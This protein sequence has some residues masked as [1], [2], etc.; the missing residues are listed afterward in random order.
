MDDVAVP[1]PARLDE[2]HR[3]EDEARR[4]RPARQPRARWERRGGGGRHPVHLRRGASAAGHPFTSSQIATPVPNSR[5]TAR[6]APALRRRASATP[7]WPPSRLLAAMIPAA[8]QA[9]GPKAANQATAAAPTISDNRP[10]S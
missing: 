9:T 5:T 3:D 6:N 1:A 4:L 7:A 2:P 8:A 10:L